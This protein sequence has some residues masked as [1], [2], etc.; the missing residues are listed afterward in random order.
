MYHA[1]ARTC[2]HQ[3]ACAVLAAADGLATSRPAQVVWDINS[4]AEAAHLS[5]RARLLQR[6]WNVTSA[7][8]FLYTCLSC[9]KQPMP[10]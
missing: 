10:S 8:P 7:L 1:H 3:S 4:L 5:T 2:S 9:Q 6:L